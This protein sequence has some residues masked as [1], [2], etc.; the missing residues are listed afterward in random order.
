M[1]RR[2]VRLRHHGQ[3]CG[4]RAVAA[5][6]A[7]QGSSNHNVPTA[8][9]ADADADANATQGSR[10]AAAAGRFAL[11][12]RERLLKGCS[13]RGRRP[14]TGPWAGG[15]HSSATVAPRATSVGRQGRHAMIGIC[16]LSM[17]RH[18]KDA[19]TIQPPCSRA[20]TAPLLSFPLLAAT[21]HRCHQAPTMRRARLSPPRTPDVAP[22][23]PAS[24]AS[25]SAARARLPMRALCGCAG[26]APSISGRLNVVR[27]EEPAARPGRGKLAV[28]RSIGPPVFRHPAAVVCRATAEPV[29][30]GSDWSHPR[31]ASRYPWC[32][33]WLQ[34]RDVAYSHS[35]LPSALSSHSGRLP[36]VVRCLSCSPPPQLPSVMVPR[37]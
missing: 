19:S 36:N 2:P 4:A 14:W 12:L 9:A 15:R 22:C 17:R 13:T 24:A 28:A 35:A 21:A 10:P 32:L 18:A 34:G 23:P 6:R 11:R 29:P 8:T 5:T 37:P 25:A 30:S 26:R 20:P 27:P 1:T 31:R 7:R 33:V 16:I 3:P